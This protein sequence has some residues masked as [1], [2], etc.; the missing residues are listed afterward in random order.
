MTHRDPAG[1]DETDRCLFAAVHRHGK[2][3]RS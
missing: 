3:T 1:L 2:A